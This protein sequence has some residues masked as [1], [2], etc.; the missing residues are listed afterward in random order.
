MFEPPSLSAQASEIA[1]NGCYT[2][3]GHRAEAD[4]RLRECLILQ[5]RPIFAWCAWIVVR[6]FGWYFWKS[7][8]RDNIAE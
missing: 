7:K 3:L 1:L 4:K 5:G 8:K 2:P 6:L